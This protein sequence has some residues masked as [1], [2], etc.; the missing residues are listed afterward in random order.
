MC[1][2]GGIGRRS[3]FKIRRPY[4]YVGSSPTARTITLKGEVDWSASEDAQFLADGGKRWVSPCPS[5]F[6]RAAGLV[7]ATVGQEVVANVP[8]G[9]DPHPRIGMAGAGPG[10]DLIISIHW[11]APCI[12][13]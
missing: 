13:A 11:M 5:A 3:G 9:S 6:A 1:G 7:V 10:L 2:R 8:V 4:G 12:A